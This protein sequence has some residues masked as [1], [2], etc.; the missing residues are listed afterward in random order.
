MGADKTPDPSLDLSGRVVIVTGGARGVGRG[1][2]RRFL[3]ADQFALGLEALSAITAA[4]L[5]LCKAGG[6]SVPTIDSVNVAEFNGPH[7][8][9]LAGTHIHTLSPIGFDGEEVWHIG[10]QD[11]ISLG[12]LVNTGMPWRH[13]VISL[14]GTG[15]MHPRLIRV[16]HCTSIDAVIA[17]ELVDGP[18]RILSGS[19]L[20]GRSPR[21]SSG[22]GSTPPRCRSGRRDS[23]SVN[24]RSQSARPRR[25]RVARWP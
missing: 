15:V 22:R 25:A 5:F 7:P 2:T 20:S 12:H 13:R 24:P 9:G 18:T 11:V 1:I 23:P 10:Y 16:A 8:A 21:A 19:A 6:A 17:G 14:A 4:P 3:D